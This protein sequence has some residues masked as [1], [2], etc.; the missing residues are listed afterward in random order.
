VALEGW[1][2]IRSECRVELGSDDSNGVRRRLGIWRSCGHVRGKATTAFYRH[3]SFVSKQRG[4]TQGT[5]PAWGRARRLAG[6]LWGGVRRGACDGSDTRRRGCQGCSR[7][8]RP[9][10]SQL[11]GA[12]RGRTIAT[13]AACRRA[14]AQEC[15]RYPIY[16]SLTSVCSKFPIK[17]FKTLNTKVVGH[18]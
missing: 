7:R 13:P 4:R 10:E 9:R 18:L 11:G 5:R 17:T 16:T 2:D 1:A 6:G 12:G 14:L 15:R 3:L 8:V